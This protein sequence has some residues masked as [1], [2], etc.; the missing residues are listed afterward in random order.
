VLRIKE[1]RSGRNGRLLGATV[2]GIFGA[3]WLIASANTPLGNEVAVVFRVIGIAAIV[4]LLVARRRAGERPSQQAGRVNLF[5]RAYWQIVAGETAALAIGFAA[6][7]AA[8]APSQVYRPW[9]AIVVAVHFVAFR[10]AGVWQGSAVW[11]V[12]P[13]LVVGIAGFALAY[14]PDANW[15]SLVTGV[16]TGLILLGGTLRVMAVELR[17]S[18][19]AE[20]D[21]RDRRRPEESRGQLAG[22][23]SHSAP[24]E[25]RKL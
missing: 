21:A 4:V 20:P 12:V 8:G 7:A 9:T 18:P 11:P 6:F 24:A 3:I 1:M 25:S 5:G 14:T 17:A 16:G 2:G 13:L 19:V 15:V 22:P 10:R 23:R